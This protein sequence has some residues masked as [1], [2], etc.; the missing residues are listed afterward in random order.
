[1]LYTGFVSTNVTSIH[2]HFGCDFY[3]LDRILHTTFDS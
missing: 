1:M 2:L 3:F